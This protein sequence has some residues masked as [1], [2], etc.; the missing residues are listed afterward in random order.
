MTIFTSGMKGK[1]HSEETKAKLRAASKKWWEETLN[2]AKKAREERISKSGIE[3][4]EEVSGD[5]N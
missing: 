4:R 5:K 3:V 2:A 1:K